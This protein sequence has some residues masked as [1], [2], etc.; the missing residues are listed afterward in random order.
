MSTKP[1]R[2]RVEPV[3]DARGRLL[4]ERRGLPRSLG[5]ISRDLYH[6]LRTS[7][8]TRIWLLFGGLFLAANVV[9]ATVLYLGDAQITSATGFADC[10][11]FSIQTMGTIGYGVLAPADTLANVVVTLECFVGIALTALITG[12]VFARFATA[13]ARVIF[14]KQCV[15]HQFDGKPCLMFRMCNARST[16][17]VEANVR[18]YV[19]RD[20]R[21]IEG[22]SFRRIYDLAL[23]R[24]NSPVFAL[25]WVAYHEIDAA[26]PL[27]GL[28]PEVIHASTMSLTVTFQGID[29][30]LAAG[31]HTRYAYAAT[32]LVF[33]RKFADIIRFDPET[34]VR[35]LDFERFDDIEPLP[36]TI[37]PL[38]PASR[39][40]DG[41]GAA[42]EARA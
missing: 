29:D 22:E 34:K 26:S 10:F 3:F 36:P 30:R 9:F 13:E 24:N 4:I 40:D 27:Y 15:I 28:T 32:D 38:Y 41:A 1:K 19:A 35:F 37:P 33:D 23:R 18:V 25:S 12:V 20:E 42:A 17:I 16:A 11:W 31:I 5:T 14:S 8:W 21:T 39:G 7:T 2:T 6:F